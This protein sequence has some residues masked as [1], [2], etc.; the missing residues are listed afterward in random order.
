[1]KCLCKLKIASV[2]KMRESFEMVVQGQYRCISVSVTSGL[3]IKKN[4]E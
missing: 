2:E 3:A 1:M 4:M